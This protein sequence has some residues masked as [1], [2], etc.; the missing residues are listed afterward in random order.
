MYSHTGSRL[1]KL[2]EVWSM[3]PAAAFA[4]FALLLGSVGSLVFG[5]GCWRPAPLP[6]ATAV[7]QDTLCTPYVAP[8]LVLIYDTCMPDA[9]PT[10][11]VVL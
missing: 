4:C 8:G 11:W 7:P 2:V 6:E 3:R 5:T 1:S 9:E 10:Q